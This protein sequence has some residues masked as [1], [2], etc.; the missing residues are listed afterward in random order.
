MTTETPTIK[1]L[2]AVRVLSLRSVLPNYR[3]QGDL[4]AKIFAFAKTHNVVVAGPTFAI[5]YTE[6]GRQTDVEVEV[7]L[8][9]AKDAYVPEEAPFSVHEVSAVDRGAVM[10]YVGPCEGYVSAYVTFFGWIRSEKLTPAGPSRE[11][12]VKRPTGNEEDDQGS[13]TEI[14]LPVA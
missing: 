10:V 12:Y 8:P 14:Q 5:N 3:A 13:V 11:V 4:W 9:T 2:A 1:S 7:C 6:D